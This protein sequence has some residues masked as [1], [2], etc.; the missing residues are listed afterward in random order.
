MVLFK[1]S[2]KY[3]KPI[4]LVIL[5]GA[6][7]LQSSIKTK[8]TSAGHVRSP[9]RLS[10]LLRVISSAA[11]ARSTSFSNYVNFKHTIGLRHYH[12]LRR[13]VHNDKQGNRVQGLAHSTEKS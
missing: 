2:W 12:S 10:M 3:G 6:A 4:C 5:K 9:A 13:D 11:I 7:L 8:A 1:F